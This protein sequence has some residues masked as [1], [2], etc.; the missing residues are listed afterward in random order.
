MVLD[1][2]WWHKEVVA[3]VIECVFDVTFRVSLVRLREVGLLEGRNAY[4]RGS[5][6]TVGRQVLINGLL[7]WIRAWV[8][9]EL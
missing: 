9:T 2:V 5:C 4:V 1:G 6:G 8:F 3:R 7:E